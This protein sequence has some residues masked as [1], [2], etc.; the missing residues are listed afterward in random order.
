MNPSRRTVFVCCD[1]L[2]R[3]WVTRDETPTLHQIARQSLWCADHRAIF[4]SATRASAAS[5]ATGCR[6][7]RH[8]LHGNRMGLFAD[9]RITV[10]D[11]GLPAFRAQM[12]AATGGTLR[13]PSLAERVAGAGGFIAFSNVSPGAAYFLDPENFGFVYHRAGSYAPGGKL[14]EGR[15][16]LDVSHDFAGDWAMTERF[17]SEVLSARKPSVA[18]LWLANPDLTLHG[19]QLG[20]PVHR[21]ALQATERCVGAVVE[22]VERARASGE[23]I[24]LLIGSDH[25]QETIGDYVEIET[26]LAARG[27]GGELGDGRIAVATQ[28]TAA[29]L[30]STNPARRALLD[31]LEEMRAEPWAGEVVTEDG[32]AA[33]GHAASSGVVAAVNMARHHDANA[34]GVAGRRWVAAEPGKPVQVG[35]GQHGGWGPDETQPFLLLNGKDVRSGVHDRPSS[36]VDIAPTILAFLGLPTV[37]MDGASLVDFCRVG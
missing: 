14:I 11:V 10:R 2:G 30:Y 6:P 12:R 35:C 15:D 28:G 36:L 7:A 22:T 37:G 8:G 20:S 23:N 3:S 16:A 9:G 24:L 17:C 26:W 34:Y 19:T 29:L 27:L 21:A 4:P 31:V 1:G 33:L 13:V 25:G 18:V 5:V 32:L